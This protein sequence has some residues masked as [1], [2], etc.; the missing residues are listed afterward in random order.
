MR[1]SLGVVL[2]AVLFAAPAVA[3]ADSV[4]LWGCHGPDGAPLPLSYASS[5]T[6]GAR[7][8]DGCGARG[9][10]LRLSA[11]AAGQSASVRV[12]V[13]PGVVLERVRL[14]RAVVP[15]AWA[16]T[17]AGALPLEPADG[18]VDVAAGGSWV[19]LGLACDGTDCDGVVDLRSLA[20]TV[21]DSAAPTFTVTG[22][23]AYADGTL[24]LAVD[25]RDAGIGLARVRATLGGLA[26]GEQL[27]PQRCHELSA[28]DATVDLPLAEDCPASDR[29]VLRLDTTAI[30]DGPNRLVVEVADAAGNTSVQDFAVH[31]LN[32]PPG[33]VPGPLPPPSGG[34]ATAPP[35]RPI[36]LPGVLRVSRRYTVARDGT[37]TVQAS[38]PKAATVACELSFR[39]RARLPGSKRVKTIASARSTAKPGKRA[40]VAMRLSRAARS[41]V[42]KRSV[43]A[44]L[45]LSGAD[46]VRVTL[47]RR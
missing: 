21:R 8:D 34:V 25:A 22:V 36:E 28:A 27:G 29:V 13:P 24:A 43:R 31:V 30:A 44:E 47:V 6:A 45:R 11:T 2:L 42:R 7:V 14:D 37:I 40:R 4:R 17:S 33:S 18:V 19:E 35:P 12:A 10:A 26:A 23:P 46:P 39:L 20:L 5:V 16:R 15:G 3:R 32:H 9:G 38:C 41:A 1:W